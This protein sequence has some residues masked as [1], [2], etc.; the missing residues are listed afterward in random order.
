MS[1]LRW[2]DS[3]NSVSDV[4]GTIQRSSRRRF[5]TASRAW[6]HEVDRG[7]RDTM[8]SP[9][10][11]EPANRWSSSP[12]RCCGILQRRR[13]QGSARSECQTVRASPE[14]LHR[15]AEPWHL[16]RQRTTG[17]DV[18]H[19]KC[20]ETLDSERRRVVSR[21]LST[22]ILQHSQ[23]P[24]RS[25]VELFGGIPPE[26]PGTTHDLPP[27]GDRANTRRT[28]RGRTP[29]A[30]QEHTNQQAPRRAARS[31]SQAPIFD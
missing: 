28:T 18:R 29:V 10:S 31:R 23:R 25:S 26:L 16:G 24:T 1:R 3:T 30:G 11:S 4:P 13:N 2:P 22:Q 9:G 27:E 17:R 5:A 15:L 6:L 19:L 20:L 14:A 12:L 7:G 21:G 8:F